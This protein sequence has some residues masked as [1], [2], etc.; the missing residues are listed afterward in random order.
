[1]RQF[2]ILLL[3]AGVIGFFYCGDQAKRFEAAPEGVSVSEGWR[4]PATRWDMGRYASAA[5]AGIGF[6]LAMFPK[7]R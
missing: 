6:L 3:F 4:Y 1:M 5:G 7:G 2:G